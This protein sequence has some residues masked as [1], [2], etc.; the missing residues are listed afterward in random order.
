MQHCNI[1]GLM[2]WVHTKLTILSAPATPK[3]RNRKARSMHRTPGSTRRRFRLSLYGN[4]S[5]NSARNDACVSASHEFP[6]RSTVVV[7]YDA[8]KALNR[9]QPSRRKCKGGQYGCPGSF[10]DVGTS[11]LSKPSIAV[12]FQAGSGIPAQRHIT[13]YTEKAKQICSAELKA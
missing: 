12:K 6:S 2:Y 5:V 7:P 10:P 9:Y 8:C 13:L 11:S 3:Q 4:A 1:N